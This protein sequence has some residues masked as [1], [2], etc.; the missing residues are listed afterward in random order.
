V[1]EVA[2]CG[3]WAVPFV[4]WN[5]SKIDGRSSGMQSTSH[6]GPTSSVAMP[7]ANPTAPVSKKKRRWNGFM[8][9]PRHRAWSGRGRWPAQIPARGRHFARNLDARNQRVLVGLP[10]LAANPP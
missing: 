5:R 2:V 6:D 10:T 8:A 3:T 7:P 1:T 4:V 9:M